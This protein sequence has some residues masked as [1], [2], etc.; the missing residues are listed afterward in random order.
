MNFTLKYAHHPLTNL[1]CGRPHVLF[2][3]LC[4]KYVN[5]ELLGYAKFNIE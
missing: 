4:R 2:I 1:K 5:T 3:N